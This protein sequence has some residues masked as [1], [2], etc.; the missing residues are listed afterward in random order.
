MAAALAVALAAGPAG[1]E[2]PALPPS[3]TPALTPAEASAFC[4]T[5]VCA[6]AQ[7]QGQGSALIVLHALGHTAAGQR[8]LEA[9]AAVTAHIYETSTLAER[10]Q[11][12]QNARDPADPALTSFNIWS[13][14]DGPA[15]AV[16]LPLAS[17]HA[18]PGTIGA[19]L[20]GAFAVEQVGY[21]KDTFPQANIYGDAYHA[22]PGLV[23]DPRP[24]LALPAIGTRPWTR[25]TTPPGIV[26]GQHAEW[27]SLA[28]M[29]SF[30]SGHTFFG[31]TTALYYATLAPTYHQ[32]LFRAAQAYALGRNIIGVHYALDV[33]GGRIVAQRTLAELLAGNPSYS[34]GFPRRAGANAEAFGAALG[35]VA[36]SPLHAGCRASV[37]GC[38]ASGLIPSAARWRAQRQ[39]AAWRLTYGLPPM[40]EN[41][42]G[43]VVPDAAEGLLAARFPYLGAAERRAVL[44]ST[45]LPA[46]VPL[47]GGQ[48][49]A[50]LDLHAAGGGYGALDG[51]VTITLDAAKGGLHA[52][53]LWTNDITGAG[54]LAK[55][56]SGTLLLAGDNSYA[57]GTTVAEGALGLSGSLTG[58]LAIAA[59]ASVFSTGGY[60]VAPDA[61]LANAGT[62]TSIGAALYNFGAAT[63]TGHLTGDIFNFGTLTGA[64]TVSGT[65]RNAGL[66]RP[67]G[68]AIRLAADAVLEPGSVLAAPA[69]VPILA[70]DGAVHLGGRLEL[71]DDAPAADTAQDTA[72]R[73]WT[74]LT[75]AGGVSGGFDAVRP[76]DP[77]LEAEVRVAG[78]AVIVTL[79]PRTAARLA[80]AA[81]R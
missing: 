63:N 5:P 78:T 69:G 12:V 72:P 15:R 58:S 6:T 38:L 40:G 46:N 18:L 9:N 56:G 66:L 60:W 19:D 25:D 30:P 64:G 36:V 16:M 31:F 45:S 52:F 20:A 62:F 67:Q 54:S 35:P 77:S 50:R 14:V 23:N 61:T 75:A 70:A 53:D 8:L 34:A 11:A 4:L 27:Q 10:I 65:L 37:A 47:D 76:P 17:G 80:A 26:A 24:Y 73:S 28:T 39:Q 13:L 21:L 68:G 79:R 44:A 3:L 1:A 42:P 2:A 43:P 71:R 81:P 7:Q 51:A 48:G 57:G 74:L 41:P 49:W 29:P 59:G 55:T 33:I 32:E 22:P